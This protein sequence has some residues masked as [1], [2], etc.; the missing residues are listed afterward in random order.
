MK[1]LLIFF[2][3]SSAAIAAESKQ[4]VCTCMVKEDDGYSTRTGKGVDREAAGENLKLKLGKKKCELTP[5][6][7]GAGCKL[8]DN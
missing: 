1:F 6:C 3:L 8:D 5:E 2:L 7:K 4:C